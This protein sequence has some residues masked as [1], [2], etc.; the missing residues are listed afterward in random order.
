MSAS[1]RR[2]LPPPSYVRRSGRAHQAPPPPSY[3]W[4]QGLERKWERVN[5]RRREDRQN[6]HS[7]TLATYNVLSDQQVRLNS[8][9][10]RH[11]PEHILS[12]RYRSQLIVQ[13]VAFFNSD[14]LCLQEVDERHYHHY[15][16]PMLNGYG[17]T[18]WYEKRT[19]DKPDGCAIFWKYDV[20]QRAL[21]K[22][23][24]FRVPGCDVLDRD[25]VGII[26]ILKIKR[27]GLP[28]DFPIAICVATTHLLF[29]EKRGDIKLAQ[30]VLLFTEI[31]RA[32][33]Q[34]RLQNPRH[35]VF[36]LFCGD[37]N[38][39]P[40]SPLYSFITTGTIRYQGMN[41]TT[42]SGQQR[43]QELQGAIASHYQLR[44]PLLPDWMNI[45]HNCCYRPHH[46]THH[47]THQ[48]KARH[49]TSEEDAA[50]VLDL[51]H[52]FGFSSAYAHV[53]PTRQLEMTT[54][55]LNGTKNT[56]D[57]IFY[58]SSPLNTDRHHRPHPKMELTDRRS[59]ISGDCLRMIGALP[60]SLM[61][62][63]H[64]A[65]QA[66]FKLSI[67]RRHDR[68]AVRSRSVYS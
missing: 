16:A 59:L 28:H 22:S 55:L 27:S 10:Y 53:T 14:V 38:I 65:L 60:N 54:F 6:V 48:Q 15:F 34:F 68:T 25:N 47:S 37:L 24:R 11:L 49:S 67:P 35:H 58:T 52:G 18:G 2:V 64:Q 7:L 20:F 9:L 17:Y 1:A 30:L 29:N 23:V 57:Y 5:E 46:S 50:R 19:G 41:R 13:E 44:Y 45:D 40:F 33:E 39:C 56:V 26:V 43:S 51:R 62:S 61:P 21:A 4:Y 42:L 12:W 8:Q 3:M 32:C 31:S 36:L 63:D 66:R